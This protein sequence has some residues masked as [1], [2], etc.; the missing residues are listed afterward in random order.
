MMEFEILKPLLD[1]ALTVRQPLFDAEQLSALRLFAGFYEG[2][3]DLVVDCYARTLLL[4]SYLED[5]ITETG[6]LDETQQY[7]LECL[8]WL[9][10]VVQKRRLAADPAMKRGRISYGSQPDVVI[11]ESGVRYAIDLTLNQDASF[12]LDTRLLRSWLKQNTSGLQVLNTFAYTGSFGLAALAGGAKVVVQ[13]DLNNKFMELARRSAMLNRLDLGRMKLRAADF[14][15]ETARLKRE[16]SLFD[17]AIIDPP[18]FSV[19]EKGT[20]DTFGESTR[21]INKL[22]PLVKDNGRLIAINNALFL[23]GREY[24]EGLEA[25]CKDGYLEIE[26]IILIP[27][28][29]T[30]YA[31]TIV[32]KPPAD[33]A[34]FNHSTKIVVMRVK[35]KGR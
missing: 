26:Q 13:V 22:R 35:R 1:R 19:T 8:P 24:M 25:L 30:G 29:I 28:D 34:P 10:C 16:G 15:S 4:T 32:S 20:V 12:Y 11:V 14:F 18:F 2:C 33:P 5:S 6:L 3:P 31:D 21:L 9:T 17:L 27:E 23:S 7:L